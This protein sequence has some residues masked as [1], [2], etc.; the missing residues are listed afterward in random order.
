MRQILLPRFGDRRMDSIRTG[1]VQSFLISLIGPR[2]DGKVSRRAVSGDPLARA[3]AL[4]FCL[5]YALK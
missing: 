3:A 5:I 1:E 2:K 4:A